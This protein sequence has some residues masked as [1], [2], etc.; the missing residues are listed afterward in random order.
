MTAKG[1]DFNS[2]QKFVA[3]EQNLVSINLKFAMCVEL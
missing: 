3:P 2:K 1:T